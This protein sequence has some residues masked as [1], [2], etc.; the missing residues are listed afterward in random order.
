MLL[1]IVY[2]VL[3]LK[4]QSIGFVLA[5]PQAELEEEKYM[6]LPVGF[7]AL[8]EYCFSASPTKEESLWVKTSK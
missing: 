5:F 3:D 2:C 4:S 7:E 6:E 1:L 8:E